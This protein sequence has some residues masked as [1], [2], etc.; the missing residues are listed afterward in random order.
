MH[1]N[2]KNISEYRWTSLSFRKDL[3]DNESVTG[4]VAMKEIK[5]VFPV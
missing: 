2:P 3:S 5:L 4:E 1:E